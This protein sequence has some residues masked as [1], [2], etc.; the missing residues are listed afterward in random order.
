MNNTR[1]FTDPAPRSLII[2]C[3]LLTLLAV[4]MVYLAGCT[5]GRSPQLPLQYATLQ[6][7]ERGIATPDQVIT[8]AAQLQMITAAEGSVTLSALAHQA[9]DAVGYRHLEP[10]NRLLMDALLGDVGHLIAA[11]YDEP[12]EDYH[13]EL[14]DEVLN[15]IIGAARM[16]Q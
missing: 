10:S 4:L 13:R 14:I 16:H 2:R 15:W 9:R 8:H 12:L 11:R 6:I 5:S 3:L 1:R 7:I